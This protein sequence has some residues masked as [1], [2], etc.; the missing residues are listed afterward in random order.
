MT[1]RSAAVLLVCIAL[2][3]CAAPS[4]S[5]TVSRTDYT[6]GEMEDLPPLAGAPEPATLRVARVDAPVHLNSSHIYY[7]LTYADRS[8]IAS[9]SRSAWIAPPP[10]LGRLIQEALA[11]QG[12]WRAVIGAENPARADYTLR[13]HLMAFR[14]DFS[15]REESHA[16]MRLHASL[17]QDASG[18]IRGTRLFT[19]RE[20]AATP[21]APGGVDALGRASRAC[22]VAIAEWLVETLGAR[23]ES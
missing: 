21:D 19:F 22:V 10:V 5:S 11:Q 9:Y 7:R 1:R 4:S 12:G 6:L 20:P 2:A 3:G 8:R 23:T 14:Q 18:E 15:A 13:L 17:V 16:L